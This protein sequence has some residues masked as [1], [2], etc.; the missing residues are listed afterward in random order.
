MNA[1]VCT[2]NSLVLQHFAGC[3]I[4]LKHIFRL[5]MKNGNLETGLKK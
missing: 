2:G 5:C 1:V 3:R 4:F